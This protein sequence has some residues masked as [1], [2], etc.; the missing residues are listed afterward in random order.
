MAEQ[1]YCCIDGDKDWAPWTVPADRNIDKSTRE[2]QRKKMQADLGEVVCVDFILAAQNVFTFCLS[3]S[4]MYCQHQFL[5][6]VV[7]VIEMA[8]ETRTT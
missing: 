6:K 7:C 1:I 8:Y 5:P 4:S 2:R 3:A